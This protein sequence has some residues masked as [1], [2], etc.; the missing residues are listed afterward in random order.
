MASAAL[1]AALA[2]TTAIA[3]VPYP[4]GGYG[5]GF[6]GGMGPGMMG[7]FG[8]YGVGPGVPPGPGYSRGPGWGMGPGMM[9]G[10]GWGGRPQAS[11]TPISMDQAERASAQF[12]GRSGYQGLAIKEIMEF[13][14]N[15]YALVKETDTGVNA[16]ELLV[17][18]YTGAVYPEPGPNMMWNT[19]Y[20]MA[21]GMMGRGMMGPGYGSWG[22][23]PQQA[24]ADLPVK[25]EQAIQI[26]NDYLAE[27]LPDAKA[28]DPSTFYGYYTLDFERDGRP[29]GMLSVNGYTG[30]VWYH[31]WHGAFLQ[32]KEFD[33]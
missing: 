12:L 1:V 11:S 27:V 21:G 4:P 9:G 20:G 16:F 7:R 14:N 30:Q 10:W 3:Q 31:T 8:G 26:A 13:E 2:A 17:D 19:K 5:P 22:W 33:D 18:R 32:E 23:G 15:L 28:H 29:V 25:P 6:G 24:T